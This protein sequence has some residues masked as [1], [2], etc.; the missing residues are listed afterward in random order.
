MEKFKEYLKPRY[1]IAVAIYLASCA[2]LYVVGY[3]LYAGALK[4]VFISALVYPPVFVILALM[5]GKS[6]R[7]EP[8][9]ISRAIGYIIAGIVLAG[10]VVF[11][12]FSLFP[13]YSQ[14]LLGW[15]ILSLIPSAVIILAM[16]MRH[17]K[18]GSKHGAYGVSIIYSVLLVCTA[19]FVLVAGPSTV[20]NGKD[21]LLENG[22]E[23]PSFIMH[24]S[25]RFAMVHI[26]TGE[27]PESITHS[28][29]DDP[30]VYLFTGQ[31]DDK[32]F[33]VFI[34]TGSGIVLEQLDLHEH[35]LLR[36]TIEHIVSRR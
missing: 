1:I 8:G 23:N 27:F 12:F 22:Y 21:T 2:V 10:A 26:I 13:N 31:R 19:A 11:V 36:N 30:G 29:N 3:N 34:D 4:T 6:E 9:K 35:D 15:Q 14:R 20:S 24:Y 17:G 32:D 5:R 16:E 28:Y 25:D 33:A 7:K 18:L